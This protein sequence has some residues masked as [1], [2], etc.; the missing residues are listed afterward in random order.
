MPT[1]CNRSKYIRI[2]LNVGISF[3]ARTSSGDKV[4]LKKRWIGYA[5][6]FLRIFG[7]GDVYGVLIP[8]VVS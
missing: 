2:N 3:M 4:L 7:L 1:C 8:Y 6:G 5:Y